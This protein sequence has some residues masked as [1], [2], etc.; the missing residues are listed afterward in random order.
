MPL[1]S[2]E[3]GCPNLGVFTAGKLKYAQYA[4]KRALYRTVGATLVN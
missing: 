4:I 1:G 3:L 2:V